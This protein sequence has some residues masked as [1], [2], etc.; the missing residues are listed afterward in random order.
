M[1]LQHR[2]IE[3]GIGRHGRC[4][5]DLN[6]GVAGP[7]LHLSHVKQPGGVLYG[8]NGATVLRRREGEADLITHAVFL[9]VSVELQKSGAVVASRLHAVIPRPVNQHNNP[10]GVPRGECCPDQVASPVL[11]ADAE[12]G[13]AFAAG[14]GYCLR[15]NIGVSLTGDIGTKIFIIR[16]PPPAVIK[17][18]DIDLHLAADRFAVLVEG[19]E[20]DLIGTV[21]IDDSSGC[22]QCGNIHPDEG[23]IR[24]IRNHGL[25]YAGITAFFKYPGGEY[26]VEHARRLQLFIRGEGDRGFAGAV[27]VAIEDSLALEIKLCGGIIEVILP[28]SVEGGFDRFHEH[29]YG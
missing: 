27:D 28:V 16:F 11:P 25:C 21:S 9:L 17:L 3:I 19:H 15:E 12:G 18:I 13:L 20:P 23:R 2:N 6:L 29:L 7:G 14:C 1:G 22:S 4:S 24:G 8:Y 10:G 26:R 5:L